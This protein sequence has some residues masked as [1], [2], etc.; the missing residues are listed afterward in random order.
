[1]TLSSAEKTSNICPWR[2]PDP[3]P[4]HDEAECID[5][6][7]HSKDR[8]RSNSEFWAE[9]AARLY[10][11]GKL[12]ITCVPG[13]CRFARLRNNTTSLA[14]ALVNADA[15]GSIIKNVVLAEQLAYIKSFVS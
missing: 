13:A 10:R 9:A 4:A 7:E 8:R 15:V 11:R 3:A 6:I 1:M 12:V 2:F 14:A 5:C